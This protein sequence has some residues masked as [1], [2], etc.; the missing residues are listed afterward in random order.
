MIPPTIDLSTCEPGD[1]V[2]FR[3]GRRG[4][5]R[6]YEQDWYIVEHRRG[7]CWYREKEGKSQFST[8]IDIVAIL[9][10]SLIERV[11]RWIRR[12]WCK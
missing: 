1:R 7:F 12:K 6:G 5:Y 9:G 2:R 10:P 8:P 4:K 11:R 3:D